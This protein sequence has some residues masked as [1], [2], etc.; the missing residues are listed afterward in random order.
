MAFKFSFEFDQAGTH[1]SSDGRKKCVVCK[2]NLSYTN[3]MP[4]C[5]R[6]YEAGMAAAREAWQSAGYGDGLG[7][8]GTS[9]GGAGGAVPGDG[10]GAGGAV[11]GGGGGAGGAVPGDGG[12]TAGVAAVPGGGGLA[13][14]GI[15]A[16]A[17][18]IDMGAA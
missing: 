4:T 7:G 18:D 3:D 17:A 15:A 9:S 8:A 5:K 1:Q 16:V 10:G 2:S 14:G 12:G 11:P 13:N 6:C